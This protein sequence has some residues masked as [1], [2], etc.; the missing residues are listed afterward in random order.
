MSSE[1]A[2]LDE[3]RGRCTAVRV[4][5]PDTEPRMQ[6]AVAEISEH[7]HTLSKRPLNEIELRALDE[8]LTELKSYLEYVTQEAPETKKEIDPLIKAINW[9]FE[10]VKTH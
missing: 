6:S 10:P 7:L 8:E 5:W 1:I 2:C 3:I 4:N 9:L